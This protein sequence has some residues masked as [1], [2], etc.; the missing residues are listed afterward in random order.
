MKK[1]LF[2][3]LCFTQFGWAQIGGRSTFHFLSNP[4]SARATSQGG[5]Y[6]H[7]Y[8]N[9]AALA[10]ANPAMLQPAM[11][12][13][14]SLSYLPY[15]AG[16]HFANFSYVHDFKLATFQFGSSFMNY[17]K[18]FE[19]DELGNEQGLFNVSEVALYAGAGRSYQ[20]KFKFGANAKLAYSQIESYSAF[21]ILEHHPLSIL[22]TLLHLSIAKPYRLAD[23]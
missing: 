20:E 17:G 10:I 13:Y 9:D 11:H 15:F 22:D 5:I 7:L 14:M 4:V 23:S 18:M 21:R 8:A 2:I 19:Y 6:N 1:I 16:S 3:F 12:K